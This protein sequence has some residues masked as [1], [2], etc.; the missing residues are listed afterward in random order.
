MQKDFDAII[1]G[2]GIS[3]AAIALELSKNGYRTLNID[4]LEAAGYG[5]TASTCA[6]IRTH[7]STLEGTAL[8]YDSYYY[9]KNWARY[10]D[11]DDELGLALFHE[12][13]CVVIKPPSFDFKKYLDLHDT[14]NIPYEI[15]DRE[16]LL[17]TM[18]HFDDDSYFPPKRPD[19]PDFANPPTEKINPVV[20]FF[21]TAGYVNDAILSVHNIQRAAE[22]KGAAFMF[23]AEVSAIRQDNNRV[24]GI[25]LKDGS[26]IDAPVV[27]NA[28]G[29]HSF[30]INRMVGLE[31]KMK[32]KTRALRHE[33]HF[34]PSPAGFNY[35]KDGR[36]ISDGDAGG[37]HRPE[38]GNMILVGSEDPA[39]DDLEWIDDPNRFNP[40]VTID[41][42]QAQTYRLAKRIPNLRIPNQ[43]KGIAALYDASDDWIPI[44]D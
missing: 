7:Y 18:P 40:E 30:L 23:N 32:I 33:V 8:A 37:Y 17:S 36:V 13:G 16:Q 25:T 15:W 20:I 10:I 29:P 9:W 2:A 6:I 26:H 38:T 35:E 4:K 44:Y 39:C 14:L 21:P 41:Q 19:D 1:I 3:G 22:T 12:V 28:A 24:I 5:S 34:V 11:A 43:P 42:Y 27:V 31:D